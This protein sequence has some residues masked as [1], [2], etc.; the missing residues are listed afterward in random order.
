MTF[1]GIWDQLVAKDARLKEDDAA[2]EFRAANLKRLLRQVY[3]QGVK[4]GKK[5]GPFDKVLEQFKT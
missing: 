5:P 4:Q 2:V 1:Q 3:D